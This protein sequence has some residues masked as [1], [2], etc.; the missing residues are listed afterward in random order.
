MPDSE[1]TTRELLIQLQNL[2]A[3]VSGLVS[4][5]DD[6]TRTMGTTYVS[7]ETWTE[8]RTADERRFRE[9]EKDNDNQ[10]G[11]RRQVLA[12]F[13]VGLLLTLVTLVLALARVP[14]AG[15]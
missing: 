11:F 12:G 7:R 4:R 2:A 14:G 9:L 8:A 5:I 13:A 1:P 10:A 3:Q 15:S 6:L